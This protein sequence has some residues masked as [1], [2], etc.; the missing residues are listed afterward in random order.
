M[1]FSARIHG[2]FV[3]VEL[4]SSPGNQGFR[5]DMSL[6]LSSFFKNNAVM[7]LTQ[8]TINNIISFAIG[9]ARTNL[10]A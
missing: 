9:T 6:V 5:S 8:D 3:R 7:A 2:T 1:A 10:P 4:H